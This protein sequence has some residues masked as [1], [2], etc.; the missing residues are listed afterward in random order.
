MTASR[1]ELMFRKQFT[2]PDEDQE[3]FLPSDERHPAELDSGVT[4]GVVGEDDL[5]GRQ[6]HLVAAG[7]KD[8]GPWWTISEYR[9][10]RIRFCSRSTEL[11]AAKSISSGMR[12]NLQH[13]STCR[14]RRVPIT[15]PSLP[16]LPITAT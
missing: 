1:R 4:A 14:F 5:I 15:S 6:R 9:K 12:L 3:S 7:E 11:G 2:N 10:R 16:R 8:E 13:Y